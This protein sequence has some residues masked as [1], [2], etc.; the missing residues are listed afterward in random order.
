MFLLFELK[1]GG[2][3]FKHLNIN[4]IIQ[5]VKSPYARNMHVYN[6]ITF[7]TSKHA[8]QTRNLDKFS[9]VFGVGRR[10]LVEGTGAVEAPLLQERG[11]GGGDGDGGSTPARTSI[12]LLRTP[13]P[14]P[15]PSRFPP[16]FAFL[17]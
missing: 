5:H 1:N 16:N 17:D 13:P 11:D 9:S 10:G 14:P 12:S 7:I 2:V 4:E 3:T 6:P 8:V 15:P